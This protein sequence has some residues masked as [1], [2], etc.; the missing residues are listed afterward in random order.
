MAS[1][2]MMMDVS[3]SR[4]SDERFDNDSVVSSMKRRRP[5]TTINHN[6]H[7]VGSTTAASY[8]APFYSTATSSSASLESSC[9]G[10]ETD[11]SGGISTNSRGDVHYYTIP[12]ERVFKRLKIDADDSPW[13]ATATDCYRNDN[14]DQSSSQIQGQVYSY[15]NH[16]RQEYSEQ[17]GQQLYPS[18][19]RMDPTGKYD[20]TPMNQLLGTLHSESRQRKVMK[21]QG[22][23]YVFLN[24][25][26]YAYG[27][28]T[29]S[30]TSSIAR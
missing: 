7:H 15:S 10:S 5:T 11:F 3:P 27:R 14:P 12:D 9:P 1:N 8:P 18:R 13:E 16:E 29:G 20:Y 17:L 21:G 2:P 28:S 19:R 6:H 4:S 30:N 26:R 23:Q 24:G 25:H 22:Q